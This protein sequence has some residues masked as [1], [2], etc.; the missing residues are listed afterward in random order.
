MKFTASFICDLN[1]LKN[2]FGMLT[3][4][5]QVEEPGNI[6]SLPEEKVRRLNI[7]KSKAPGNTFEQIIVLFEYIFTAE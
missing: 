6:E 7:V 4:Y 5:P 1:Y 3:G 2:G